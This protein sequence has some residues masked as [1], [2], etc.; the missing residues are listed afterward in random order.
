MSRGRLLPLLL[1]SALFFFFLLLS[2]ADAASFA[3]RSTAPAEA[4]EAK[5]VAAAKEGENDEKGS[6]AEGG[7]YD[8]RVSKDFLKKNIRSVDELRKLRARL[9]DDDPDLMPAFKRAARCSWDLD[10]WTKVLS[11]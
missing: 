10:M 5:E 6:P 3:K 1:F 11:L 7:K 2:A 9:H 8:V 4:V